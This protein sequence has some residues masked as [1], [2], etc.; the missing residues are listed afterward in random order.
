MQKQNKQS[1]PQ[2]KS[3]SKKEINEIPLSAAVGIAINSGMQINFD[4]KASEIKKRAR[5]VLRRKGITVNAVMGLEM[6]R[7]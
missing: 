7:K 6:Y 3:L 1:Q 5:Q 2:Q 4:T